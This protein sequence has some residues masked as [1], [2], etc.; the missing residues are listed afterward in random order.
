M[1]MARRFLATLASIL[2]RKENGLIFSAHSAC[3]TVKI[4][5]AQRN[6][7]VELKMNQYQR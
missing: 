7:E 1:C 2:R 6:A 5:R 3:P 4:D